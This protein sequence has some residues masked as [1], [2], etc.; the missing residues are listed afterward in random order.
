MPEKIPIRLMV[1]KKVGIIDLDGLYKTMYRW[2]YDNNYANKEATVG[3]DSSN[4]K[5]AALD[6]PII[7]SGV[8]AS[9][10]GTISG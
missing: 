3:L 1:I 10:S 5:M 9:V 7:D 6:F 2:F 4:G 8:T